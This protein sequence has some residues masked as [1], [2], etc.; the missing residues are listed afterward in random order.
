MELKSKGHLS[1]LIAYLIFGLNI[2]IA[3]EALASGLISPF[4][5][6]LMRICGGALLFWAASLA[7]PREPVP[8]RD[9]ALLF[10]ASMLGLVGNQACFIAGL[11]HTSSI[12]ASIISTI[13][14]VI[15]MILAALFLREPIT[16][17]KGLGVTVGASGALLLVMGSEQAASLAGHVKGDLLCL[18]SSL[19]FACYL[20]IFKP[21]IARYSSFTI[22]KW[23][24][25]F[26]ALVATPFGYNDLAAIPWRMLPL[27][28]ILE[29]SFVVIFATF[30]TYMLLP[31]GQRLLRPTVVSSYNY[32]QPLVAALV[33]L[34]A[35]TERFG[36]QKAGAGVLVFLGVWIVTKSKSRAQLDAQ[37][38]SSWK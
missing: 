25:L 31:V 2:P 37:R 11:A 32:M 29:T 3:K 35:G 13:G 36:W 9:I 23:M 30:I 6:T 22:M 14:P 16:W 33:A 5:L 12:N 28:L 18:A 21:L 8:L 24:F 7:M 34:A 17:L 26:A 10:M 27:E 4:S 20:T 19:C 1:L 15:T 38:S